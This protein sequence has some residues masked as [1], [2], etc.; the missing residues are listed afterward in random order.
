MWPP[1][2]SE[3]STDPSCAEVCFT[4]KQMSEGET[5]FHMVLPVVLPSV[6]WVRSFVTLWLYHSVV[7]VKNCRNNWEGLK[8]H[9][10]LVRA[11][12]NQWEQTAPVSQHNLCAFIR[13]AEGEHV[14]HYEVYGL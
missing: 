6:R 12:T 10:V 2:D 8:V 9:Q 1:T 5:D 7:G 13:Q 3:C 11:N 14:H 4:L